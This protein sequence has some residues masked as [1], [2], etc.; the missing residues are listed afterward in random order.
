MQA[1]FNTSH[2]NVNQLQQKVKR[3]LFNYFNTSHVNVN[4][5][6][7]GSVLR[8]YVEFQYISC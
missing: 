5:D 8:I 1:Y 7:D 4:L 3:V 2:V 6:W